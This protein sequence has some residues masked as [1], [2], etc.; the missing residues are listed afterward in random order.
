[1]NGRAIFKTHLSLLLL[2]STTKQQEYSRQDLAVS[3]LACGSP[4]QSSFFD[5]SSEVAAPIANK[6]LSKHDLTTIISQ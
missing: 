2:E 1:M 3:E 5:D 4:V 6:L